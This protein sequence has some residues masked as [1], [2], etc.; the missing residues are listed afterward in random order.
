MEYSPIYVFF[1]DENVRALRLSKNYETMLGKPVE[2]LLG[3]SMDKLFPS[4]LAKNMVA[5]DMRVMKEG[6]VVTV[7]EEL[8]DRFYSTIKFPIFIEGK[9]RYL[10][11]YTTDITERKNAENKIIYL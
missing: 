11:G 5:D 7:E 4:E 1:K 3:K 9:P 8:D 10:A 6:K 2:E